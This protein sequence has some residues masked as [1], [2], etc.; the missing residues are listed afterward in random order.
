MMR[1]SKVKNIN[2]IVQL[3]KCLNLED[4][5]KVKKI[6]SNVKGTVNISAFKKEKIRIS[7]YMLDGSQVSGNKSEVSKEFIINDLDQILRTRSIERTKYY[8][9]RLIKGLT[10]N[11]T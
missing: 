11:K 1:E 3:K 2:M 10:E 9:N 4:L 7:E 5:H 8:I 6:I